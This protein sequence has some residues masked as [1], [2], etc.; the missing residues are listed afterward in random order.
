MRTNGG[1]A[2]SGINYAIQMAT[3]LVAASWASLVTNSPT[4]GT[5]T[6]TDTGATNRSRFYRAVKQ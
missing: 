5:F 6:F 1:Q 3:N 4:N 2:V